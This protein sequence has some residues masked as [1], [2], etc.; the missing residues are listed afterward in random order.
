M[1]KEKTPF[2]DFPEEADAKWEKLLLGYTQ[3]PR[4]RKELEIR[5][6]QKGCPAET[7]EKL[8]DRFEEIG[9]IDDR[10]YAVL[11]IDSKKAFGL[12]RLRDE[13]RARG[14]SSEIVSEVLDE[15]GIDE[16]QRAVS[17]AH[18]WERLPGM[19]A[20]KLNGR[21][22][23]RGFSGASVR[24]ALETLRSEESP[25]FEKKDNED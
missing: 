10:M 6:R 5:M 9:I 14:V 18:Q 21:L 22:Q 16:V 2:F 17:L 4:T 8:L 7:A 1:K 23:R 25:L 19:T 13:L 24:E 15:T 11:Y 3:V 12:R 20:D